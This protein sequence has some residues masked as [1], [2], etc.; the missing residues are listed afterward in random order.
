M[1]G[2]K[3]IPLF[4]A[5][6]KHSFTNYRPASLLSQFSKVL[7]KLFEQKLDVFLETNKL[8]SESQYGF[9][10]NRPTDTALMNITEDITTATDK[11]KFTIGVFID[12]K[13]AFDTLDHNILISKLQSYGMR[14]TISPG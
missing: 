8:L 5:G 12:F 6:H 2:A 4:K 3:V 1:K 13:K 7:E 11:S 9:R 10:Q 14:G